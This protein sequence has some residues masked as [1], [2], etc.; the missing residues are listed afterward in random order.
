MRCES[1]VYQKNTL[2]LEYEF[3]ALTS[4]ND[5][6]NRVKTPLLDLTLI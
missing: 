6:E 5:K 4:L 3:F 1:S 2:I